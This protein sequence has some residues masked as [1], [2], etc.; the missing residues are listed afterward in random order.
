MT[1][2]INVVSG[3]GVHGAG[4]VTY[5]DGSTVITD[6]AGELTDGVHPNNAGNA[7]YAAFVKAEL[8]L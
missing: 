4:L 2:R 6:T 1:C 3:Y 5:I 7:T 8:G